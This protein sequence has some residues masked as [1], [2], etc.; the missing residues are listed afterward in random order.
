M[1][2]LCRHELV[3]IAIPTQQQ[4]EEYRAAIS[5]RHPELPDVWCTRNGLKLYLECVGTQIREDNKNDDNAS[6][7]TFHHD[8]S[9]FYNDWQHDY[10]VTNVF[11][12]CP[13]GTVLIACFNVPGCVHD[14]QVAWWENI[15]NKLEIVWNS[16]GL[17]CVLDSAF[18]KVNRE[19][20]INSSR[21]YMTADAGITDEQLMIENLQSKRAAT[22]MRRS[23]EWGMRAFQA[24]F[25][26]VKDRFKYEETD[27][28]GLMLK[29]LLYLSNLW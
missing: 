20:L 2:I 3:K 7:M 9:E 16:D 15:Y 25:P 17:K 11:C 23:T 19:F 21:D 22:S 4:L 26:R 14:S 24:S 29:F 12:F 13:D 1:K 8:H 10:Y 27:E 5:A 6:H 28:C 18:R